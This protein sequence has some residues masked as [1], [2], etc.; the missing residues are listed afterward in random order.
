[1]CCSEFWLNDIHRPLGVR[2]VR[3]YV[4]PPLP[5]PSSSRNP[6]QGCGPFYSTPPAS[7]SYHH[8]ISSNHPIIISAS[9]K[10]ASQF[11][12]KSQ[13]KNCLYH[14]YPSTKSH[15]ELNFGTSGV[16]FRDERH[17]NAQK[18]YSSSKSNNF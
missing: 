1:M 10:S 11:W 18:I 15:R 2:C 5:L 17:G 4:S 13:E 7:V 9:Q 6:V 8:I 12:P 16:T 14:F 3:V